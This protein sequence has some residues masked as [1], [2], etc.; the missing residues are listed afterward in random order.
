MKSYD[1]I[2]I[3]D[4][5]E[6]IQDTI[7]ISNNALASLG[8]IVDEAGNFKSPSITNPILSRARHVIQNH[9]HRVLITSLSA[10]IELCE[11]RLLVTIPGSLLGC[12]DE[13]ITVP[14]CMLVSLHDEV[15]NIIELRPLDYSTAPA[16]VRAFLHEVEVT[17]DSL[18][19]INEALSNYIDLSRNKPVVDVLASIPSITS[20]QWFVIALSHVQK[21]LPIMTRNAAS[22][23]L[24]H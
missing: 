3:Q 8:N 14:L 9:P 11:T 17:V 2:T 1:L 19:K 13:I 10:I 7:N 22:S 4:V 20:Q 24:H 5:V 23:Y 6:V 21:H 15:D 18:Y 16:N 12:E